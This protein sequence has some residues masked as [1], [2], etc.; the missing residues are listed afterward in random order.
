MSLI[1]MRDFHLGYVASSLA[2][3]YRII[4]A[5][6]PWAF[7]TWSH[8]GQGKGA[9]QHYKCMSIS[10]I[11]ALP[12]KELAARDAALFLWVV[13]PMLEEALEVINGWGFK[14]RTV[15]FCWVKMPASWKPSDGLP[16]LQET[17]PGM[18]TVSKYP[19]RVTP[20]LGLGYHTRSGMEQCWLAIRGGGYER[21]AQG[22]E[23]VLL[24]PVG[25][26]SAKPLEFAERIERLVGNVPRI[27]LFARDRKAGWDV[28]G[29]EV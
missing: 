8:R 10:N 19:P 22:V 28:W 21:L 4:Y 15:A 24:A 2:N 12:V 26:H 5:D 14:F 7:A 1:E 25:A 16:D 9:S 23:Q 29:N 27:E 6:P 3:R 11:S 13:Q 18:G 17:L 20:R